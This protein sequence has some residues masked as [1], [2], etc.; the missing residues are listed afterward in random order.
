GC[1]SASRRT[2]CFAWSQSIVKYEGGPCTFWC[3]VTTPQNDS[4]FW[5]T[6]ASP[7][8]SVRSESRNNETCPGECPGVWTHRQPGM[9]GTDSSAGRGCTRPPG[10]IQWRGWGAAVGALLRSPTL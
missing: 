10:L 1:S 2:E 5:V 6:N 4:C 7:A 8:M 9:C 3:S